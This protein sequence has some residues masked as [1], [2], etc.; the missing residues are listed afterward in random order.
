MNEILYGDSA[1]VKQWMAARFG[2]VAPQRAHSTIVLARD[3]V[4]RGAVWLENYNGASAV[5]HVAGDGRRWLT[6]AFAEA[7]FHYTFEVLGCKKLIGIVREVNLDAQRFDEH[8]GFRREHV[9]E[10]ADPEGG[11]IIY[12]LKREDCKF[13]EKKNG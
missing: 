1:I 12:S 6:R 5:I 3:G 8:L 11:L 13:L 7:V 9:I 4:I 2:Q 10:D